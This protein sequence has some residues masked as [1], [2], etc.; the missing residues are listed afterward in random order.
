MPTPQLF[1][2]HHL[3]P[4]SLPSHPLPQIDCPAPVYR[5]SLLC[6]RPIACRLHSLISL[7]IPPSLFL[8]SSIFYLPPWHSHQ[9]T[10]KN[11]YNFYHL[12]IMEKYLSLT[13]P[14]SCLSCNCSYSSPMDCRPPS[15]FAHGIF[16]ARILEQVAI[17]SSRA[18]SQPRDQTHI[19]LCLLHC[20]QILYLVSH[21]GKYVLYLC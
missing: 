17:S 11:C 13:S 4:H 21:Q 12:K 20:K 14:S 15:S 1:L 10:N 8:P 18:S 3:H 5:Q 9:C 19:S 2:Y 7:A 16:Q 6:T